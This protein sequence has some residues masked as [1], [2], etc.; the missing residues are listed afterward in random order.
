MFSISEFDRGT[1]C[2]AY[3]MGTIITV[4]VITPECGL[5]SSFTG[6]QSETYEH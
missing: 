2:C 1:S 6:E 5:S 3:F 4:P